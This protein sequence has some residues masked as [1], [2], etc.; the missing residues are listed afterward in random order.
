MADLKEML[1]D[2]GLA[3][4]QTYIQSGNAIFESNGDEDQLREKIEKAIEERFGFSTTVVLRTSAELRRLVTNCPFPP[5]VIREAE[6]TAPVEVL[7]VALLVRPPQ[8]D[9]MKSF[10]G[11]LNKG[12]EYRIDGRDIFLL[13]PNG[14]RRSRLVR[15]LDNLSVPSTIRN[16]KTLSK[17]DELAQAII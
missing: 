14:I 8:V 2:L 11:Y 6:S 9:A 12:E 5:E 17:L 4:V 16:W 1:L 13:M 15:N 10:D 7:Y 3:R